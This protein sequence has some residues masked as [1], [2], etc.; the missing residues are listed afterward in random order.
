VGHGAVTLRGSPRQGYTEGIFT[1]SH[2][3]TIVSTENDNNDNRDRREPAMMLFYNG[4]HYDSVNSI[5]HPNIISSDDN[6]G[7][8]FSSDLDYLWSPSPPLPPLPLPC[9]CHGTCYCCMLVNLEFD[10]EIASPS[11]AYDDL[12]TYALVS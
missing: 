4:V 10:N 9:I 7:S 8:K 12:S 5:D 1:Y 6:V 11:F 3:F 2:P